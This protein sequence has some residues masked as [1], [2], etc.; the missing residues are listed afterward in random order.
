MVP[1]ALPG[2]PPTVWAQIWLQP[3]EDEG[4]AQL[5]PQPPDPSTVSPGPHPPAGQNHPGASTDFSE[6]SPSQ[7]CPIHQ[8]PERG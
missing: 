6:P 3:G 1:R 7:G 8:T 4:S 5:P 2:V